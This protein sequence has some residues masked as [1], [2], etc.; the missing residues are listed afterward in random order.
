MGLLHTSICILIV[1][2]VHDTLVHLDV[3]VHLIVR[4]VEGDIE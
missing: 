1:S 2:S 4:H 3:L